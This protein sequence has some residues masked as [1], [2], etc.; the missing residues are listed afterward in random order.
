MF[1]VS[2]NLDRAIDLLPLAHLATSR[3]KERWDQDTPLLLRTGQAGVRVSSGQAAT[4]QVALISHDG[5]WRIQFYY[6]LAP[7]DE[8]FL[9]AVIARLIGPP[10]A[11]RPSIAIGS[12][13]D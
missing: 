7:A 2:N 4:V 13:H 1:S 5:A 12:S 11:L 10:T 9:K 6:L 8:S 3:D